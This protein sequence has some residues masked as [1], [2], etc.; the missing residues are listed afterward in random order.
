MKR[1]WMSLAGCLILLVFIQIGCENVN[2]IE[3]H[4]QEVPSLSVYYSMDDFES[5]EIGKDTA[6]ELTR[7][8]GPLTF[9][10]TSYGAE[11]R[12]PMVDGGIIRV[13][14]YGGELV[15]GEIEVVSE[16]DKTI[17]PVAAIAE[18]QMLDV[19]DIC[20]YKLIDTKLEMLK[21]VQIKGNLRGN[22][23]DLTLK[24]AYEIS[25]NNQSIRYLLQKIE[26]DTANDQCLCY[27]IIDPYEKAGDEVMPY[28]NL[29][30]LIEKSNCKIL[31]AWVEE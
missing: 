22:N 23:S 28:N 8:F 9:I 6:E 4:K 2:E 15:V 26:Y 27:F 18:E 14:L 13:R 17:N 5:I 29:L 21:E 16:E 3:H 10:A 20:I 25:I 1:V 11:C 12:F 31:K 30:V 19:N 24:D 7:L